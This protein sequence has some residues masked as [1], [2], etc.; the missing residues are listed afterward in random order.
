MTDV[1]IDVPFDVRDRSVYVPATATLVLADLHLGKAAA[2]SVNAPI[3]DGSDVLDRLQGL[4]EATEPAT[5]VIA[6]DLLH[7]FSRL[8]RGVERDLDRL[9]DAVDDAGAKLIVTPGNHDTMLAEAFDGETAAEYELADGETVVCH[10][11]ERPDATAERYIVGHDHPALA[12]EGR[13][14]PCFLYG[15]DAFE[16]ADVLVLPAFTRLAAGSTVNGKDG[17]DF[18][19]PLVR[20]ADG[21]YPAVRDDSSGET[22]WFP[23]LGELRRLL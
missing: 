8:P 22:L 6:G 16:G 7:S 10:G 19:T 13:K 9:T 14:R 11:H 17:R 4:L 21:F 12:I 3:D 20:D 18:Q 23:P 15:P 2:S 1:D 5:V